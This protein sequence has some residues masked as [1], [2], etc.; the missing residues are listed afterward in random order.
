MAAAVQHPDRPI[1]C[2]AAF[3]VAPGAASDETQDVIVHEF[4][5]DGTP[6]AVDTSR[7]L[8]PSSVPEKSE[9]ELSALRLH[10]PSRRMPPALSRVEAHR[11]PGGLECL[12]IAGDLRRRRRRGRL[13]IAYET[14]V[15]V[16]DSTAAALLAKGTN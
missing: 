11:V 16:F 6:E 15:N 7:E 9:N 2:S 13:P 4:R 8:R 10:Q 14:Y 3:L 1:T 5:G 12:Q